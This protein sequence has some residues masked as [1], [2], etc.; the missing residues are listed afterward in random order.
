MPAHTI[1]CV[2]LRKELAHGGWG[3]T[4]GDCRVGR[5]AWLPSC[6]MLCASF[7]LAAADGA[8]CL[9]CEVQWSCM[10]CYWQWVCWMV[11][12]A[13]GD[14]CPWLLCVVDV[15]GAECQLATVCLCVA[16][17]VV[18]LCC[19]VYPAAV[20]YEPLCTSRLRLECVLV[21]VVST[22]LIQGGAHTQSLFCCQSVLGEQRMLKPAAV[23][24]NA[25]HTLRYSW[26][27][28]QA[29]CGGSLLPAPASLM[30]EPLIQ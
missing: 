28:V 10:A 16:C 4:A 26:G 3:K 11:T 13:L 24:V 1:R 30:A 29:G 12:A 27:A 22:L 18:L 6:F 17:M 2:E 15:D 5:C 20:Q 19:C 8:Q 7:P 14:N 25:Y 21:A 23:G 9:G